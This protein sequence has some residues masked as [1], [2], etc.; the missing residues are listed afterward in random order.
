M[1]HVFAGIKSLIFDCDGTLADTMTI[2][3]ESWLETMKNFGYECSLEFLRPFRGMPAQEIV[4][5]FNQTFNTDLDP[6]AVAKIKNQM[7]YERLKTVR[8]IEPVAQIALAHRGKLPMAVVSGGT[9]KN[10]IRTLE[11]INM[12]D[13]FEAVIT[14][15]DG[16]RPK[17]HPQKFLEAAKR[18]GVQPK[19]CQVFEDGEP[20]LEAG[21]AAGMRVLDVRPFLK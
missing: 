8:P 19:D 7:S 11:A 5:H 10:V 16:F 18:M 9:R 14:V 2:H 4:K 15:D 21:L 6:E 12:G 13:F 1:I 3:T 17:P 20:G